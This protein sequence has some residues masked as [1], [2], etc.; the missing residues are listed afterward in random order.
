M[1]GMAHCK[2]KNDEVIV[3]FVTYGSFRGVWAREIGRKLIFYIL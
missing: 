2:R 1:G 3:V